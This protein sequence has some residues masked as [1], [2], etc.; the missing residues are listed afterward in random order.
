MSKDTERMEKRMKNENGTVILFLSDD[1]ARCARLQSRMG[2]DYTLEMLP[3][4]DQ[5]R[6]SERLIREQPRLLIADADCFP[7]IVAECA[8]IFGG[9]LFVSGVRPGV[10]VLTG[11]DWTRAS[12]PDDGIGSGPTRPTSA[13]APNSCWPSSESATATR[14][15]SPRASCTPFSDAGWIAARRS[16]KE[17]AGRNESA[18]F[19]DFCGKFQ[20]ISTAYA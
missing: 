5:D 4:A 8:S 11:D 2:L 12:L 14:P 6:L 15:A 18:D 1:S 17:S 13:D 20:K 7:G 10:L 3:T 9:A 19:D 16:R